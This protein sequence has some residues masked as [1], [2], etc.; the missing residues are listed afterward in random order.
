VAASIGT[1]HIHDGFLLSLA[2]NDQRTC[3]NLRGPR[4]RYTLL[5]ELAKVQLSN[6]PMDGA[7]RILSEDA[8]KGSHFVIVTPH[9]DKTM[10][11]RLRM[12]LERGASVVIVKVVWDESDPQSLAR[13]AGLGCQVVQVPL[14]SSIEAAFTHQVG[15]GLRR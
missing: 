13:A 1:R 4:A 6:T 14:D 3:T 2:T 9:L 11:S 8:R 5:D 7:G 12:V 15:A 10:S